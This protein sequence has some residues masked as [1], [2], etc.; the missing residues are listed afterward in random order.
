MF[1]ALSEISLTCVAPMI[2][3]EESSQ[4]VSAMHASMSDFSTVNALSLTCNDHLLK[5]EI[6]RYPVKNHG[7]M[8]EYISG[9]VESAKKFFELPADVKSQ[10]FSFI[11]D[12][13]IIKH[14]NI[15]SLQ[16]MTAGN[17]QI[18]KVMSPFLAK[19]T[20]RRIVVI[21]T[22]ALISAMKTWTL[23]PWSFL[24]QKV[25]C[26]ERTFGLLKYRGFDSKCWTTSKHLSLLSWTLW[27]YLINSHAA[28]AL[29]KSLFPLFAL[30]LDLPENFFDD[31]VILKRSSQ[32]WHFKLLIL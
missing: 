4:T 26:Q 22:K 9:S 18:L 5:C 19:T 17:R 30:A 11:S 32:C 1:F 13:V 3:S 7:I 14:P 27:S 24:G 15:V 28:I 25:P 23:K 16:S 6:L 10:V 2:L 21:S 8:E 20:T 12:E 31:K 29:G